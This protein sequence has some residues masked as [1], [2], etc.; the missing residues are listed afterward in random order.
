MNLSDFGYYESQL[1]DD[2]N[3][4]K[5]PPINHWNNKNQSA[6]D[7]KANL[8][9]ILQA[10]GL[11]N[12]DISVEPTIGATNIIASIKKWAGMKENQERIDDEIK[13][14]TV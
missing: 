13:N 10:R 6:E 9:R 3:A 14:L 8:K 5:T 7:V 12:L 11:K 4:A 2:D 1:E